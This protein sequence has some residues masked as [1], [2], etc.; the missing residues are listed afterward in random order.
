L[1]RLTLRLKPGKYLLLCNEAGH[2][3]AGMVTVFT[4]TR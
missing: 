3:K 2:Y 1:R 4:V